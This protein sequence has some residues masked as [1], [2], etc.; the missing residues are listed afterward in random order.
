MRSNYSLDDMRLFVKAAA[1]QSL[2]QAAEITGIPLATLSRRIKNLETQLQ[3][4]LLNRSAHYFSLTKEGKTY[5]SLCQPLIHE[6]EQAQVQTDHQKQ[7]LTG[8]IRITAPVNM[9]QEWLKR[10]FYDF[11]KRYP[12]VQLE[13]VLSNELENLVMKEFDVAFRAGELADSEWIAKKLWQTPFVLCASQMY[14]S[15]HDPIL[16][17]RQLSSHKLIAAGH[18]PSWLMTNGKS[19]ERFNLPL[20]ETALTVNDIHVARDAAAEGLGITWMPAYYFETDAL[21]RAGLTRL[22]PDWAG[23]AKSIWMMYRD[24]TMLSARM[25]A[26]IEHVQY[27]EVPPAFRT[28]R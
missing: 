9:T 1:C 25:K 16:H 5:F 8:K 19:C 27:L 2:T 21:T 10:C 23:E 20:E 15:Q 22:L 6:L 3:C 24:R 4:R 11:M 12:E 13:L 18:T 7:R 17:P 28:S 14:L 26:F